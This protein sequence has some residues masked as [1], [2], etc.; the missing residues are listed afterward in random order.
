MCRL[1]IGM[2]V[3]ICLLGCNGSSHTQSSVDM[4]GDPQGV[5]T[6]ILNTPPCVT[7][8]L[9]QAKRVGENV[10][11]VFRLDMPKPVAQPTVQGATRVYDY[12]HRWADVAFP[13]D[14]EKVRVIRADGQ[15]VDA[16]A[17]LKRGASRKQFPISKSQQSKSP[18]PLSS[19]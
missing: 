19:Q 1:L 12:K 10:S 9:A 6:N 8:E 13:V 11:I 16:Q 4:G 2:C 14:G 15:P 18:K 7:F 3:G 5:L 17:L